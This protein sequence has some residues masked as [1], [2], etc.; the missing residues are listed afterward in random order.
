MS[1]KQPPGRA[2]RLPS[3]LLA[4]IALGVG[5]G[6][7][8]AAAEIAETAEMEAFSP[9]HCVGAPPPAEL[10]ALADWPLDPGGTC[11]PPPL[12]N[13]NNKAQPAWRAPVVE[14]TVLRPRDVPGLAY[15]DLDA[16]PP[17]STAAVVQVPS[18]ASPPAPLPVI[19]ADAAVIDDDELAGMRGGFETADGLKLSFGIERAVYINGALQ[20]VTSL[21]VDDLGKLHGNGLSALPPGTA[22]TVIQNGPGNQFQVSGLSPSTLATVVQ[23]SL[24]NQKIQTVTTLS[25]TVNSMEMLR[26]ARMQNSVQEALTRALVR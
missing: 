18:S 17:A 24:D 8:P 10:L 26:G 7:V 12:L 1:P 21:N 14:A 13:A 4:W 25:A 22:L 2:P 19:L 5:V 11:A 15:G 20:S 6:G 16:S 3:R 23:N 9:A